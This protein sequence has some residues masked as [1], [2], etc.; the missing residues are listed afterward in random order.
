MMSICSGVVGFDS[1]KSPN[2]PLRCRWS[3]WYNSAKHEYHCGRAENDG[4][5]AEGGRGTGKA[6]KDTGGLY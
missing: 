3:V 4:R 6:A 5:A 2:Q 1:Q